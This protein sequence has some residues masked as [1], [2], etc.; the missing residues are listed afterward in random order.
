MVNVDG[1][2]QCTFAHNLDVK[3][4]ELAAKRIVQGR[5]VF[6]SKNNTF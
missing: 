6:P 3:I 5:S 2:V 4:V 1:D